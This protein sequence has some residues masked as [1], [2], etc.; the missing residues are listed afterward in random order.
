MRLAQADDNQTLRD[1]SAGGLGIAGE[2]RGAC[3][4]G[5][6]ADLSELS[7]G[8]I[9]IDNGTI[10]YADARSG[11]DYRVAAINAEA[12][13]DAPSD[14]F[15]AKGN[16]VWAQETVDFDGTLTVAA[17]ASCRAAGQAR[18]EPQGRALHAEL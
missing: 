2:R 18:A 7:L 10:R 3:R 4:S 5:A 11:A 15:T 12:G 9:R 13:L 6:G 14:P 8:D 1:F 17:R 16:F